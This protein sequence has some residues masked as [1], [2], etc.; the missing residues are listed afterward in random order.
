[1]YAYMRDA[2]AQGGTMTCLFEQRGDAEGGEL[3]TQ[4]ARICGGDNQRGRCRVGVRRQLQQP[5]ARAKR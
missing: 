4:F 5:I 1:M 2:V 3:A